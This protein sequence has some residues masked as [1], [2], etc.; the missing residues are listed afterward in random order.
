[1][2]NFFEKAPLEIALF[3]LIIAAVFQ[4]VGLKYVNSKMSKD[5]SG[6][7]VFESDPD[8]VYE[9]IPV[10]YTVLD[11]E[12]SKYKAF[13]ELG[14]G[15]KIVTLFPHDQW[16][17]LVDRRENSYQRALTLDEIL[18]IIEDTI[19]IYKENDRIT[20]GGLFS[21]GEVGSYLNPVSISSAWNFLFHTDSRRYDIVCK[22]ISFIINYRLWMHDTGL[23]YFHCDDQG[24]L[25]LERP[26]HAYQ[27]FYEFENAF[28]TLVIGHIEDDDE[29]TQAFTD[30]MAWME[31]REGE[32]VDEDFDSISFEKPFLF[33]NEGKIVLYDLE[34][35]KGVKLFP[36]EYFDQ[37]YWREKRQ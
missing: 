37:M 36:N 8:A 15:K 22:D 27:S 25:Y 2:R 33:A 21:M 13:A 35:G 14:D 28:G 29:K 20:L 31:N 23:I 7:F 1:M 6:K 17:D 18:Y 34:S 3:L 24:L 30:L 19:K 12:F 10:S 32:L 5:V 16:Y 9:R 11:E 4:G 26:F